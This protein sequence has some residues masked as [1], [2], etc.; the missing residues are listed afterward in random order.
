MG[1]LSD[2]EQ[3]TMMHAKDDLAFRVAC[4]NGHLAIAEWLWGLCKTDEEQSAMLHAKDNYAFGWACENGQLQL[5]KWLLSLL[6]NT[7]GAL[8]DVTF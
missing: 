8:W 4:E 3:S 5:A 1:Y 2:Q 7:S 6:H